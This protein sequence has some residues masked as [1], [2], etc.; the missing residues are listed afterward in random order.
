MQ[1]HSMLKNTLLGT[2]VL[3][4][5]A[6]TTAS[7]VEAKY[8]VSFSCSTAGQNGD[9]V[10]VWADWQVANP[11]NLGGG[12]YRWDSN[13]QVTVHRRDYHTGGGYTDYPYTIPQGW[14]SLH[15][16]LNGSGVPT[17]KSIGW[18]DNS[19]PPGNY[20]STSWIAYSSSGTQYV[21]LNP[22]YS[23]GLTL[24]NCMIYVSVGCRKGDLKCR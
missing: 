12:Q 24:S 2:V 4:S 8:N 1:I 11:A 14:M 16:L 20:G 18:G 9:T 10:S 5:L 21:Y 22:T 7:A 13:A 17:Y 15:L 6:S 23:A 3:L 19:T